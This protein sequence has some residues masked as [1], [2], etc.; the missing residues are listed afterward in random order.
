[1]RFGQSRLDISD[2]MDVERDKA[3]NDADVAKDHR[4][5]R[6]Q[7]IDAVLKAH[8]LDAILTPGGIGRE[9]RLARR[10]SDHRRA[11]RHGAQRADARRCR[12]ASTPSRRRLASTFTGTA[13]TEPRLIALA[14]AFE[15]AS[16]KR[17]PP[18]DMP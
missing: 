13:C 11:V 10:L 7:G 6:D 9:S 3:R 16:K 14:Y 2:E 4:L 1:M 18:P 8:K 15:Q 12:P 17:V 5:S